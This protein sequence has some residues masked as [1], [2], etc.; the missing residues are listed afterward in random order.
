M[1]KI[2][3]I[4]AILTVI[5]TLH[6]GAQ[7]LSH[8]IK[9]GDTLY[10]ISKKY[11]IKIESLKSFNSIEDPS[12][13]YPGMSILIPGGYTVKKGDT[14]YSIARENKTTVA[15]LLE[16]NNLTDN[17]ILKTDQFL[18]IP[19]D[20]NQT[21]AVNSGDDS[22]AQDS[23]DLS[24]PT[25]ASL[26]TL[27]QNDDR[28]WPHTGSRTELTGKLRGIQIAG[29]P[30]DDVVSVAG[31]T[32][33]WASSYGI[34]KKLVLVEGKNG[35]VYGYGGN[36]ITSVRVGDYVKPGS[37]IGVLGGAEDQADA[38]FFVY[39]D[40]KPIDPSKAPRV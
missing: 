26:V 16:L 20:I 7:N 5:F 9:K 38:F 27:T 1:K 23:S 17:S 22:L 34:F 40:G 24:R 35:L 19:V 4:A 31:G 25:E 6:A 2:L 15:E 37:I 28:Q 18:H 39:K 10:S 12:K 29:L 11:N 36:E 14:L 30:G 8:T 21:E 13:L 3:S 32:V 33:V